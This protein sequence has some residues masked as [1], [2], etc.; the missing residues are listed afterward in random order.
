MDITPYIGAAK[1]M[2]LLA[3]SGTFV[4]IIAYALWPSKKKDFDQAA[5]LPLNED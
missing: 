1:L 5:S 4:L 3:V 2:S